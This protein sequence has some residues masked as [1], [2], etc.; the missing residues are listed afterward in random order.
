MLDI[1]KKWYSWENDSVNCTE[2]GNKT[3]FQKTYVLSG[4]GNFLLYCS[5]ITKIIMVFRE[6]ITG[7][8]ETSVNSFSDKYHELLVKGE[9]L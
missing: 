3:I 7:A 4:E 8:L 1:I 9:K 2:F 5:L 6:W